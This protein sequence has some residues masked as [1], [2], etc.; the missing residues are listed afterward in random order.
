[1]I[2]FL[3]G[4]FVPEERAVVS[5]FDRGFLYGDALFETLRFAGGRPFRWDLHWQR[6]NRGAAFLGLRLPFREAALHEAAADLARRNGMPDSLLRL[7]VS[8]G[9]G[10]RGYSPRGAVTPTVVLSVHPAPT[11]PPETAP[12]W[13]LITSSVRLSAGD[14]LTQF[15][16]ANKLPQVVARA[17][18]DAQSADEALMLSADG[19]VASAS[20]ANVFWV[21]SEA[22]CTPPLTSGALPGVTRQVVL[23]LCAERGWLALETSALP[24]DLR[25]A[26][27]VFLTLSSWGVVEV[28]ALDGVPLRRSAR[29]EEI[30]RAYLGLLLGSDHSLATRELSAAEPRSKGPTR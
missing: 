6:L 9:A 26:E 2:V 18:A 25:T 22:V 29:V 16:T 11:L 24:D 17:A 4:E 21:T 15:K 27:G 19:T 23:E 1:M 13:R 5:V 3:N 8:R 30:R 12:G 20:S 28:T 7:T 14:P 10:P